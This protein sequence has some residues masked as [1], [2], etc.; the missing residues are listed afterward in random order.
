MG[1]INTCFVDLFKK[2]FFLTVLC[3]TG[4]LAPGAAAAMRESKQLNSKQKFV[5]VDVVKFEI[6][7]MYLNHLRQFL[8][9][10]F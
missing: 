7:S 9:K 2:M 5:E 8:T 1:T 3:A 6:M 10:R 4:M